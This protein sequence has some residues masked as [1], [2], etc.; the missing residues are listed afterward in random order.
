MKKLSWKYAAATCG[1]C[2]LLF[3]VSAQA[4]PAPVHFGRELIKF[5]DLGGSVVPF[6]YGT[7]SWNGFYVLDAVNY[8]LNPSG[9]LAGMKSPNNVL[10]SSGSASISSSRYAF[11]LNSAY[12]TGAWNDNLQVTIQGYYFGKLVYSRTY[13]LSA[14]KPTLITFPGQL[15]TEVVFT[16]FG[17]THHG[18]YPGS[19]EFLATDN[20]TATILPIPAYTVF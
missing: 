20:V 9:Y 6:G 3:T 4:A 16:S 17:G 5:D 13:T 18:G 7:L 19:G 11:I 8:D 15:V 10:Y 2:L 1:A 12:L 14:V